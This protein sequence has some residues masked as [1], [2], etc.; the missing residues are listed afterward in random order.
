M[1]ISLILI[2]MEKFNKHQNLTEELIAEKVSETTKF[3]QQLQQHSRSRSRQQSFQD[4]IDQQVNMLVPPLQTIQNGCNSIETLDSP[5][6]RPIPTN[7]ANN[8][9]FNGITAITVPPIM[10]RNQSLTNNLAAATPI[11][12]NLKVR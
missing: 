8:N 7:N 1:N 6:R 10:S 12:D 5:L 3:K 4:C 9:S 11:L 2:D